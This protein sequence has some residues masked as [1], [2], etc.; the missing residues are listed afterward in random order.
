M[1]YKERI[2]NA[3][4]IWKND[5]YNKDREYE[6]C[7]K[8]LRNY[9]QYVRTDCKK[10][11]YWKYKAAITYMLGAARFISSLNNENIKAKRS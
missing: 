4:E 11:E 5:F 1:N 2:K 8:I 10:Y 7:A 6:F 3:K 9:Y